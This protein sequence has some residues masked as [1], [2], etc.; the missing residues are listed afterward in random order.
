MHETTKG[1]ESAPI[2]R[3]YDHWR[4]ARGK[5]R[6]S[7]DKISPARKQ[8]IQAR[9]KEFTEEDLIQAIDNVAK[10]PWPDRKSHD[11]IL[12]IF[13]SREQVE[14]FLEMAVRKKTLV[15]YMDEMGKQTEGGT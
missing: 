11:D 8:K 14:R 1:A 15:D 5:T 6:S 4:E 3:V 2:N 7:Y 13:R 9:L 10:D 12:V